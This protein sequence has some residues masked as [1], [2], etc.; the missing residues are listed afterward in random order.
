MGK[1]KKYQ[2]IETTYYEC[3]CGSPEHT[4]RFV[5]DPDENELYTEIH[6]SQWHNVFERIW[7]AVKYIFG[8]KCCYGCFDCWL[9]NPKDCNGI[10]ELLNRVINGEKKKVE[11][12][13]KLKKGVK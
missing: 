10:K 6:L 4:L 3:L 13:K 5:Y 11:E 8:Y 9:L 12:A 2:P 7:M 1:A